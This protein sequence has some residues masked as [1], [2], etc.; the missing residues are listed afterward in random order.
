MKAFLIRCYP[1][2]WRA[3]YGDEFAAL[4]DERRLGPFDVADI[5]LGALDARLRLRGGASDTGDERGIAM[6]LRIG[7]IAAVVGAVSLAAGGLL[8]YR[9]VPVDEVVLSV[10]LF[11]GLAALLVALTGLSAFQARIHP[12]LIWSAFGLTAAGVIAATIG[13]LGMQSAGEGSAGEGL[14]DIWF[15]GIV[16]ALLGSALF[17]IATFRT[18]SL[19]RGA[20]ALVG[21]G[22][23]LPFVNIVITDSAVL[24]Y[25]AVICFLLGWFGLGIQAIRLD[26]P[27]T[28]PRP[29]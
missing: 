7:G 4:L 19:S 27:S 26:R 14:W 1:A 22:S 3:R 25:A 16:A 5:L 8:N 18:A 2:R 13:W 20:A 17:A 24:T 15:L 10:L 12:G 21:V 9:F 11:S 28:D 6:S 29:A 23:L